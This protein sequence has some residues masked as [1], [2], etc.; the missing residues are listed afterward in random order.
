MAQSEHK[1][2]QEIQWIDPSG[3][4]M[5]IQGKLRVTIE[6]GAVEIQGTECLLTEFRV[7]SGTSDVKVLKEHFHITIPL[8]NCRIDWEVP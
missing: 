4:R 7:P 5:L 2:A 3:H 8:S 6:Y 1:L